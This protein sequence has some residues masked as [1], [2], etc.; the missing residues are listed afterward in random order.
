[1]IL[2]RFDY[3]VQIQVSG[4]SRKE[5]VDPKLDLGRR[6]SRKVPEMPKS[7]FDPT[8]IS[9][10][11]MKGLHRKRTPKIRKKRRKKPAPQLSRKR[12]PARKSA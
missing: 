12:S 7:V 11:I 1:M 6:T 8:E 9:M 10:A 4:V 5:R 3:A 2:I